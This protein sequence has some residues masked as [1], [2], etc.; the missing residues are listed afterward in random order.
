MQSKTVKAFAKINI[1]LNVVG[2]SNGYHNLDSV[3][4]TVNKYDVIKVTKRKDKKVLVTFLGKYAFIPKNQEETNAYKA[5]KLF[6]DTFNTLGC[7]VDVIRNIPSGSGMGGSSSDI[8]GVLVALKRL[9]KIDAKLKPLA[10]SLG[11]DAGYLLTGGYARLKGR[12]DIVENIESNLKLYFVVIYGKNGVN[13]KDCFSVYDNSSLT[14]EKSNI[15]ELVT[16]IKES[17]FESIYKNVKNELTN[18]AIAVNG[19][20]L[21]NINA[22]KEL[23]LSNVSMSG[24]GST[25]F[26]ICENI[27]MANWAYGKLKKKY[28]DRVEVLSS[29]D[30]KKP[31]II[32]SIF[33]T[34]YF[35]D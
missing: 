22:L 20:V 4:T 6:I 34:I 10:D 1:A 27:E 5:A 19:E 3:C 24:S 8:V 16:A 15:S 21:E 12:G 14:C 2:V 32:D 11:S 31:L 9:Y 7:N 25:V 29:Y 28:G 35:E 17:N 18:S 26:S 33:N 13:T 23:S 30:F